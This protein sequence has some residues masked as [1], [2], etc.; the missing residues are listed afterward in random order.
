M[1][2]LKTVQLAT[3]EMSL[4]D[5]GQGVPLVLVH[6]FPLD[7]RMWQAQID[8]FSKTHRVIAPDLRGLGLSKS[9]DD[10]VS[11]EQFADDLAE[12]L[13]HLGVV[14]R[15]V[16][17]GL[18]MGGYISLQ[19]WKKYSLRLRG[20]VLCDT[21]A[22]ADSPEAL[23]NRLKMVEHVLAADG[24]HY[25]AEAMLPKLF[26][27]GAVV[28]VPDAVDLMRQTILAASPR[29]VAAA[30]RGMAQRPD[31]TAEQKKVE[32]PTQIIVGEHDALTPPDVMRPM[33]AAIPGARYFE[34][35][36]SGHM[37]PLEHPAEFNAV[38]A[39]FLA[40]LPAC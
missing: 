12:M 10:V 3:F 35:L 20:I 27:P 13:D 25:V 11:M 2:S 7:H 4:V 31:M 36:G 23:A 1:S 24:T 17:C 19:F 15:V 21:R 8:T 39:S 29:A 6:G 28:R 18:S 9:D 30:L 33:A 16:L 26:A 5:Q 34:I 37:T 32:L 40:D 22:A 14:E 38:L